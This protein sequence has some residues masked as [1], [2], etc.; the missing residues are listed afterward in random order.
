MNQK[1]W[2]EAFLDRRRLKK[3]DGRPLFAYRC[4]EK[5]YRLAQ[6]FLRQMLVA[7][8][9][10]D[11]PLLEPIFC[12]FAAETWRREHQGGPW[13]W[14]TVFDPIDITMP[15]HQRISQWVYK[16]LDYWHR[17]LLRGP[18]GEREF[19]LSIV[20]E[21]GL[22]LRLLH[23]E[24]A[25]LTRYFR[26]LLEAYH[27]Q[28]AQGAETLA[29]RLGLRWLPP[30]LH[31]PAVFELSARLIESIVELQ[32]QVTDAE[33]PITALDKCRSDWR[34]Q[35]PLSLEDQTVE[36]LLGNLVRQA[37][38]L[39]RNTATQIRWRRVLC[40]ESGYWRLELR[41]DLPVAIPTDELRAWTGWTEL[42]A[43]L[44]VLVTRQA[45]TEEVAMLS[46]ARAGLYRCEWLRRYGWCLTGVAA[47][48]EIGLRLS[49]GHR[50][51]VLDIVGGQ[52]PGALPWVF[53]GRDAPV[54]PTWFAE[55]TART[56]APSA[57][58][59]ASVAD[60]AQGEQGTIECL[61]ELPE[62]ERILY[63]V[64][65]RV[66]FLS[67][68][69]DGC[70]IQCAAETDSA[71]QFLL[72]G[73]TLPWVV[74]EQPPYLGM[75]K[76]FL[77]PSEGRR[78]PIASNQL[79]WRPRG[80]MTYPWRRDIE[81]ATGPIWIRLRDTTQGMVRLR[82][83]LDLLPETTRID[84][85]I[86][87]ATQTGKVTLAGLRE[88][89]VR[90]ENPIPG[91]RI[92]QQAD[93]TVLE[94]TPGSSI[95][96]ILPLRLYWSD[97][98]FLAFSLL[99]PQR[100]GHFVQAGRIL[101]ANA[102]VALKRL[103]AVQAVA[104]GPAANEGFR[105]EVN[106]TTSTGIGA[107]LHRLLWLRGNL[108]PQNDGRWQLELHRIQDDLAMLLAMVPDLDAT[109]N[110]ELQDTSR[111]RLARVQ[112]ARF[113]LALQP[114]R[115]QRLVRID[116]GTLEPLEP[117]W[118][119]RF[120]VEMLPLWDHAAEPRPLTP[121]DGKAGSWQV[122]DDLA[123][124]PWWIIG[125]DH[126]WARFRPLLW[127]VAGEVEATDSSPLIK[128]I[129]EADATQRILC[130]D[131]AIRVLAAEPHHL[132]WELLF[133]QLRLT[134]EHPASAL[135]A[136]KT[137]IRCPEA[138]ALMLFKATEENFD[139]TWSLAEELPFAWYLLPL[140]CWLAAA[141]RYVDTLREHIGNIAGLD[142]EALVWEQFQGF[143][144]RTEGRQRPFGFLADWLQQ[145]LFPQRRLIDSPLAM[146]PKLNSAI[147][148]SWL[149]D[150][151]QEF[152]ARHD[153]EELWP[154]GP[155]VLERCKRLPDPY[156]Y[157]NRDEQFRSVLCAPAV[158]AYCALGRE[159]LDEVLLFELRR[160]RAFDP[161]W[162]DTAYCIPWCLGLAS[163]DRTRQ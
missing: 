154:H 132:D 46:L 130:L 78:V 48:G 24:G 31:Q 75:P 50:E 118:E 67:S 55:G 88:V 12:L 116:P 35:L 158:A 101:P 87:S 13:K 156:R 79:E 64:R 73:Q 126:G 153:A 143:R 95:P 25:T 58:V 29:H 160:L 140:S 125:R 27:L 47:I 74:S 111:R 39:E 16:G 85:R 105:L 93:Q 49:D 30:S 26:E 81:A 139:L 80:G 113:D 136:F 98:R 41:L 86:G 123:P 63:Q 145:R 135:E 72:H 137:L 59:L 142:G 43:R 69:Q 70:R 36:T 9:R 20:C 100:D 159:P 157:A 44:R 109:A 151:E 115:E 68:Q 141:E 129:R 103:G 94:L 66:D 7:G 124:G 89:R 14:Q 8:R 83:Q 119:E 133:A 127:S 104:Q 91:L 162:F 18:S 114:E 22:P 92:D 53:I 54:V 52:E 33:D 56:R 82:R 108:L 40:Q 32:R 102:L 62:L 38:A 131:E 155:R 148:T 144:Q 19:L 99:T 122:P 34:N 45:S 90:S 61:A 4:Q 3:P 28:R 110:L 128:A 146:A 42:P 152:R 147:I 23:Q 150:A 57:W 37:Q 107:E 15:D 149:T 84:Y 117:G 97:G 6:D 77:V 71:E 60:Q 1:Q 17:P 10:S 112:V 76:L 121:G 161:G 138:L 106:I 134:R 163:L 65:G 2:L 11:F 96:A 5:E 21:G 51:K 120:R